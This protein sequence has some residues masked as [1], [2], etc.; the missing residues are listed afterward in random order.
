MSRADLAAVVCLASALAL[1]AGAR[2]V[3]SAGDA[4]LEV[5]GSLRQLVLGTKGTS[6]SDYQRGRLL[7]GASCILVVSF[8]DCPAWAKVGDSDVL[9]SLTRG[10][11][12]L[13]L[14]VTPEWSAVVVYDQELRAGSLDTFEAQ[15][16]DSLSSGRFVRAQQVIASGD[17]AEWSQSL[18]RGYL[19]YEGEHFELS[20]GRQRIPWGV[21]RLWNPI[22]RF[23]PVGPLAIEPDQSAGVDAVKARWLISGFTYVEGVYAA[24]ASGRDRSFAARLQGVAHDV[25]Y[26][27]MAGIF[28]E[29]PTLGFDL[30]SNLGDAAGRVEV[31]F[32]DPKRSVR[33]FDSPTAGHLPSYWQVVVSVDTN[34]DVGSGVYL[35]A[36]YLYNGNALGFG[37]G[38]AGGA[39]GFFQEQTL[40]TSAGLL[41][42]VAEGTPDLFG[43]SRVISL[44]RH[45]TGFQAGYDLTPELRGDLLVLVDWERLS[46]TFFPRLAYSPFGWLEVSLGVQA[47]TGPRRSEFG[48]AETL[49]FVLAEAFF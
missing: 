21:G 6:A 33:P 27:V 9:T 48:S 46:A 7:G 1:P 40:L 30:A 34:V 11:L 18:Y 14:R 32:T 2:E 4:S 35:L 42:T 36:E 17:D 38:R 13:D 44:S 12:R 37:R 28:E 16:G 10:R 41:R 23:N 29:A 24:G 39:L 43:Q 5:S 47:A 3:W 8:P 15:I 25:D 20:V 22:D 31:V 49:G 19:Q 26:S 45:L